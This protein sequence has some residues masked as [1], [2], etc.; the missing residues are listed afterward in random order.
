MSASLGGIRDDD[1]RAH[2]SKPG[3]SD[4]NMG[5][6]W[7]KG[8]RTCVATDQ[9]ADTPTSRPPTIGADRNA[10]LEAKG[11]LCLAIPDSYVLGISHLGLQMLVSLMN[12]HGWACERSFTPDL[13]PSF[14]PTPESAGSRRRD[15]QRTGGIGGHLR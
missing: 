5:R 6:G 15:W 8:K 12:A 9:H 4:Y 1:A 10:I 14:P 7:R 13:A 2:Q 11:M 3:V